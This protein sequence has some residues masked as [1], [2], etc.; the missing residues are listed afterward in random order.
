MLVALIILA[1]L[2][3]LE[4]GFFFWGFNDPIETSKQEIM[5]IYWVQFLNWCRD[6]RSHTAMGQ[7]F[8]HYTIPGENGIP[9]NKP[10]PSEINFWHWWLEYKHQGLIDERNKLRKGSTN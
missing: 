8:E 6:G 4:T 3:T 9:K 2:L 10:I 7:Q 1:I 5:D